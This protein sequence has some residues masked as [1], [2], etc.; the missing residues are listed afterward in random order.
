MFGHGL[1]H[2]VRV[3]SLVA[4]VVFNRSDG[5]DRKSRLARSGIRGGWRVRLGR[6]WGFPR[7]IGDWVGMLGAVFAWINSKRVDWCDACITSIM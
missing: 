7:S 3:V 2:W 5:R 6:A 1:I 4:Q